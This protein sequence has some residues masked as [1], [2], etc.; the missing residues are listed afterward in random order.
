MLLCGLD[1]SGK[2]SLIKNYS[3]DLN[4]HVNSAANKI[5]VAQRGANAVPNSNENTDFFCS[6]PYIN[7]ER[8]ELPDTSMPC[9]VY[10]MSGQVSISYSLYFNS[11]II[12]IGTVS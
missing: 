8:I 5:K 9:I 3:M 4:N 10:D 6:T 11:L 2:T 1:G 12:I 7:I